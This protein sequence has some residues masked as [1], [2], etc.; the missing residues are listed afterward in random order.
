MPK[1][2]Y[3]GVSKRFELLRPLM[4]ERMRRCI[5]GAEALVIGHGGIIAVSRA[6]G[7]SRRAIATGI[8]DLRD[9]QRLPPT[10]VRHPGGGRKPLTEVDE[11]VEGDLDGLVE[12]T[13]RGDP[14]SPLRWTCK[15]V[16]IL[17]TELQQ[18]GHQICPQKVADLL[19]SLRYSLQGNR[20]TL[21]GGTHPDRNAQFEHINQEAKAFLADGQPVISVDAKKREL[22]GNFKNGGRTWRPEGEPELVEVYDFVRAELGRATPYGVYDMGRN[23]GWVSLGIDHNTAAFAVESVRRWWKSVGSS[24]YPGA[25]RLLITAD[26]GGSNGS[27]V[28][29]WKTELQ[30]LADE[31]GLQIFVCHF[32]PG[33]S[34]WNKV[35]HRLFSFVSQ[36]WRGCPLADHATIVSLIGA[37]TTTTGLT[38]QCELDDNVY[39]TGVKISD[40]EMAQLRIQ[41]H[42]FHGEWNYALFP[43]N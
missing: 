13:A 5:T 40:E 37:T 25:T 14:E 16:R 20:K 39:P 2:D 6:T 15:S 28:R 4:N 24:A 33:T 23:S 41:R 1:P 8:A 3:E 43:R 21:E 10:D 17:S 7:V 19:H 30:K 38:V 18:M 12:P 31:T 11:T 26:S 32:P 42:D 27:R 29:M 22:V 9:P 36:N 34:K 35:E